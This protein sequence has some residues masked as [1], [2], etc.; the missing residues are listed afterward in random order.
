LTIIDVSA[1]KNHPF[2]EADGKI[3][4]EDRPYS[5]ICC[6]G[7]EKKSLP[8]DSVAEE[9]AISTLAGL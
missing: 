1:R 2:V 3:V 6:A 5:A 9:E 7:S 4:V 8:A